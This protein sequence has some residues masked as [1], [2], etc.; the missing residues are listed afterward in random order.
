MTTNTNEQNERIFS[1]YYSSA[2]K[3]LDSFDLCRGEEDF[4]RVYITD[5][6]G[7]KLAIKHTSNAFTDGG[8]ICAWARLI[9]EY[10]RLG[11]YC[12][13]IVPNRDGGLFHKYEEN[14]RAF[15]VYAEEYAKFQTAEKI[16]DK[17]LKDAD[18]RICYY[19]DMLRSVGIVG[20]RHFDFCDFASGYCLLEPF[21]PSDTTD[22]ATET[23]ILLRDYIKDNL[24]KF[25][26]RAQ[27]LVE[28]FLSNQAELRKLY[29]H[30]PVSCFQADLNDSNVLLDGDNKFAGLIDFN[31]SGRDR[32]LNYTVRAA[33]WYVP[34]KNLRGEN[35]ECLYFYDKALD[36]LRTERFLYN[37]KRIEE[38]YTYSDYEREVFPTLLRYMNSF[39][40]HHVNDIK[41]I[42]DDEK[43]DA[44]LCWLERQMTRDDIRLP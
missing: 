27:G 8:R 28:M 21:S 26:P 15:Y 16:G 33:F 12:P 3:I 14:G 6:D 23:A 36:E 44:L 11:I 13:R 37:L 2:P 17:N 10:N 31:L 5:G 1:L 9:D 38:T 35:G 4:R 24:P 19:D 39:W 22:E 30:L 32:V 40:W 42:K 20:S 25:Y 18:G 34:S 7:K 29:E 43:V 41:E